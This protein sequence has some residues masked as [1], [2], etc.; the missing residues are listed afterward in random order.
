MR[1]L[2]S[3]LS[4]KICHIKVRMIHQGL[5]MKRYLIA[6]LIVGLGS[7]GSAQAMSAK[8]MARCK[9]LGKTLPVQ[10]VEI[11]TATE[12]RDALADQ[13]E[14]LG[15]AWD[16]VEVHR[17]VSATHAQRADKAEVIYAH[18]K[19]ELVDLDT[20]LQADLDVFNKDVAAFNTRCVTKKKK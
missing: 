12:K 8:E 1:N 20:G 18:A 16:D 7:T 5:N 3:F 6:L 13:V 10:Q 15:V 19:T 2:F 11:K 17:M 4:A 9:A 14:T